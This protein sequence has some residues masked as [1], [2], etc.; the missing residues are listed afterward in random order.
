MYEEKT[1]TSEVHVVTCAQAHTQTCT[2]AYTHTQMHTHTHTHT[3][4]ILVYK[5]SITA[6]V[7]TAW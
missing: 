3:N 4:T 2:H 7:G 6:Y 1:K 5:C